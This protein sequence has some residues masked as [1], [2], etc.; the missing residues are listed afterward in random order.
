MTTR[1]GCR[2]ML[3]AAK[4]HPDKVVVINHELRYSKYFQA[5]KDLIAAGEIG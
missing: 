5:I 4:A 3:A 2:R 1:D